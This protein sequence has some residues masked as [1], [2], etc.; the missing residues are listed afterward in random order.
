MNE[1]EQ[2]DYA[3]AT[4]IA[5]L[6]LV[7]SFLML[8]TINTFQAMSR[9]RQGLD[10]TRNPQ[11]QSRTKHARR[12]PRAPPGAALGAS[13]PHRHGAFLP[14][15]LPAPPS[16]F[17]FH[18]ALRQGWANYFQAI[19]DPDTLSAIRLT[20]VAAS[21]SVVLNT[22]FGISAAWCIT[23][24]EFPGKALLNALIDLP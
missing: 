23:K 13:P 19:S 11:S 8:L 21:V 2:Y 4:A 22:L 1:L 10:G 9:K 16:F 3:S 15:R 20:L 18:E 14:W 5:L 6:M 7:V 17:V 24:F 12:S